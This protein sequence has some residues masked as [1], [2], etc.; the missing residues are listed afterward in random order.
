PMATPRVCFEPRIAEKRPGLAVIGRLQHQV[1]RF[2]ANKISVRLAHVARLDRNKNGPVLSSHVIPCMTAPARAV[3]ERHVH[4]PRTGR[5][6]S[7][8]PFLTKRKV[9]CKGADSYRSCRPE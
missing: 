3:V 1:I 2:R 5:L 7:P 9:T 4:L 6:W 8:C